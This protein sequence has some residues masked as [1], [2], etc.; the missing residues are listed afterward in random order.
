[1]YLDNDVAMTADMYR[2]LKSPPMAKHNLILQNEVQ[3]IHGLNIGV[4]YC[5]NCAPGGR[6]QWVRTLSTHLPHQRPIRVLL[7]CDPACP[8]PAPRGPRC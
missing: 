6:G 7:P 2:V 5:Q 8:G 1:M 3:N 4:I